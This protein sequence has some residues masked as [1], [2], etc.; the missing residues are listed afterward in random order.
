MDPQGM[1]R[2][3]HCGKLHP[4]QILYC[5]ERGMPIYRIEDEPAKA[6][7]QSAPRKEAWIIVAAAAAGVVLFFG[8]VIAILLLRRTPTAARPTT[9]LPLIVI[10]SQPPV[11]ATSMPAVTDQLPTFAA[12]LASDATATETATPEGG[13]W[14]ACPGA[15]YL[16][17]LHEGDRARVSSD[18]PLSNRVRSQPSL[19]GEVLGYIDP[20]EGLTILE[21]PGCSASWV[22]WRV[23]AD[24]TGLEGWTAEGDENGYWL[25]PLAP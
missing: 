22:W 20:G 19:N 9:T 1:I 6:G 5:P 18:P 24:E 4:P 25:V 16:S 15:A 14:D 23:K 13:P 10:T 8:A 12:T 11:A 2:C 3:P 21:G 7:G 17:R